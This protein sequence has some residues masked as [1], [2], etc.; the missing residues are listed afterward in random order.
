VV[1]DAFAAL[2]LSGARLVG[3]VAFNFVGVDIT[4]HFVPLLKSLFG[5]L[6]RPDEWYY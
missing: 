5:V 1:G 4:F 3:A 6:K 2:A